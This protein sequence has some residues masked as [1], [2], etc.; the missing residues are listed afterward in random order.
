MTQAS[1]PLRQ[2][3]ASTGSRLCIV[4]LNILFEV[5]MPPDKCSWGMWE[6]GADDAWLR[7]HTWTHHSSTQLKGRNWALN[8]PG[9]CKVVQF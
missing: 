7:S 5:E 6:L 9:H 2:I 4:P 3:C 1:C 8:R